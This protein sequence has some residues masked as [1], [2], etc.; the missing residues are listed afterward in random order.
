MKNWQLTLLFVLFVTSMSFAQFRNSGG[1]N[2]GNNDV[3]TP[4]ARGGAIGVFGGYT[5]G[6]FTNPNSIL[7]VRADQSAPFNNF[8]ISQVEFGQFGQ[9]TGEEKWIGLGVGNPGGPVQPYGLAIVDQ[10][11]F[12]FFN[13]IEENDRFNLITN[14]ALGDPNNVNEFIIRTQSDISSVPR[15]LFFVNPFGATGVNETPFSTFWVNSRNTSSDDIQKS[16][17]IVGE[18][19]LT[20]V[21]GVTT[22][23]ST[24][25]AMGN[26]AN[27]SLAS[28]GVPVEGFRAQ[29]PDFFDLIPPNPLTGI[30]TNLQVVK[31]PGGGP[32]I[33]S[34]QPANPPVN[35][36][37]ELTW[38]DLDFAGDASVDC[39]VLD[40]ATA[41]ELDKFFISFRNNQ[42]VSPFAVGNKLPVMTFQSNG[43]VGIG[44]T[45]PTSGLG[46]C[47]GGL[48]PILLDVNGNIMAAGNF[49]SSDRRFKKDIATIEDAMD[50]IRKIRGTSYT[51]RKDEFPTRNFSEGNHYGFIAQELEKVLPEMTMLNSDGYYAVDYAM[52]IPV[53][54]E[55]L[56]E[57]DE[58]VTEQQEQIT[59][60]QEEMQELRNQVLDIQSATTSTFGMTKGYSLEQNRPNPFG[61]MTQIN[62]TL[63]DG[64]ADASV[65]VYDLN[66][67]LLKSY[68]IGGTNGTVEISGSDFAAGIY[69]YDLLVGGQQMDVKRMVLNKLD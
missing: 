32:N 35:E 57:Q 12:G 18:Q 41:E 16:I 3:T 67:R 31:S 63:P 47:S 59:Q 1:G 6:T 30:A 19:K 43:R 46:T 66:G 2:V 45:Q 26:Q 58:I 53:L 7:Q 29:I 9:F 38:Q 69:L 23:Q 25:S 15:E 56:K 44:T 40:I 20:S 37:A 17:A 34:F 10:K 61:S 13:L 64:V 5:G 33:P 27:A 39:N 22:E 54:T 11:G 24:A 55:A 36:F 14:F 48:K 49:I 8:Q 51:F 68:P 65:N 28:I 60:L 52:L 42:N 50:K 62:Y 4:M 21:G